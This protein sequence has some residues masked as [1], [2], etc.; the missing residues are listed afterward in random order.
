[1][2]L[3]TS[4]TTL[5]FTGPQ[6]HLLPT[7]PPRMTLS[8]CLR[9]LHHPM[10][11]R[12]P[13]RWNQLPLIPPTPKVHRILPHLDEVTHSPPPL[14]SI[15]VQ[16]RGSD[17]TQFDSPRGAHRKL[18]GWGEYRI[19]QRLGYGH[20]RCSP[21]PRLTPSCGVHHRMCLQLRFLATRNHHCL[22][23]PIAVVAHLPLGQTGPQCSSVL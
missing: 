8:R 21:S 18:L 7:P 6:Q 19:L 11:S 1:M 4:W 15:P 3:L 17:R 5:P 9:L 13:I 20:L 10:I 14:L 2:L 12:Q 16:S 22:R 23:L